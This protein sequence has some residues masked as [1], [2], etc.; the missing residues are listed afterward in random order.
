MEYRTNSELVSSLRAL[1]DS[2]VIYNTEYNELKAKLSRRFDCEIDSFRKTLCES[3][4]GSGHTRTAN[5][6]FP[7]IS[8]LYD[9]SPNGL[10]NLPSFLKK[11]RKL[12][13]HIPLWMRADAEKIIEEWVP[14]WAMLF[15]EAKSMIVKG[16]RPS[17]NVDDSE[18]RTLENTGTCSV[19]NG[20]FK[21]NDIGTLVGHG[22]TVEHHSFQGGC[23]GVGYQPWEVSPKGAENYVEALEVYL[24]DI[25]RELEDWK[26]NGL[27]KVWSES[28]REYVF[29]GSPEFSSTFDRLVSNREYQ[30]RQVK[31]NIAYYRERIAAWA[32]APLPGIVAGFSK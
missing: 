1:L 12:N 28:K 5:K 30:V 18:R 32:E 17:E 15:A 7:G 25:E 26:K 8:E 3:G 22:Y 31:S 10:Y 20:N 23:P 13:G 2:G 21:R 6:T 9:I 27:S 29:P 16:R 19:C 24:V 14:V 11:F 4:D